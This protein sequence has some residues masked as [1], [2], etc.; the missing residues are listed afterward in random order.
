[1]A[2]LR[3]QRP[4][5]PAQ[6]CVHLGAGKW[7]RQP[8]GFARKPAIEEK[9]RRF[10]DPALT[11]SPADTL[12]HGPDGAD[13]GARAL[14]RLLEAGFSR[15]EPAILQPASVFLDMSG[16][17]IRGRLYLTSDSD[18]AELCLRPEYTIPVCLAYLA[19]PRAGRE[20]QFSYL[21]PVF[22]ARAGHSG[23]SRQSGLES[24]GRADVE[25]ADAEIFATAMEA[26]RAAGAGP[27]T[28]RLGDAHLFDAALRALDLPDVWLRRLRRGLARGRP[29]DAILEGAGAGAGS[30]SGVLAALE[31]ADHAGA[32]ALV[33]DLLAI[34]GIA[35]VGGRSAGEIADRFLDQAAIRSGPGPASEQRAILRRFL[36]VAGDPD[37]ASRSLRALAAE[38]G[39]AIGPALDSL[40]QRIGFLAARGMPV[41]T[42][43]FSAAFVRDLDYYTGF[44]FE[45]VDPARADG[46]PAVG[47]GRYDRLARRLGAPSDIPAVGA[48]IFIDR[49]GAPPAA[50]APA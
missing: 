45:A 13:P 50:G 21:G 35:T 44:V 47:G 34:A 38:T 3:S 48:A 4:P 8:A 39:L 6:H 14:D 33:E 36:A 49:L 26:A 25:A 16:E 29:L 17:D 32:R 31:R 46:R 9:S 24:Y 40:D 42:Y 20:A 28:V 18:G 15:I 1:M 11:Q 5:A 37:A 10:R 43:A 41:E 12:D 19:S 7:L 23:E 22:R 2:A 30:Q 27:L